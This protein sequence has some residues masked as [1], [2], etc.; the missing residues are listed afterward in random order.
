MSRNAKI[1]VGV[2]IVV[3][4][5][6]VWQSLVGLGMLGSSLYFV[7]SVAESPP[8]YFMTVD[9]LFDQQEKLVE[10]N[11]R[12]SGAVIGESIEFDETSRTLSFWIA[13]VPGDYDEVEEQGGLAMVLENAVRDPNRRRIQVVYVGEKPEL[14]RDMTQAIVTGQLHSDGIFYAEELLLKC[15]SRYEEAVPDQAVD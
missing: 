13:D 7:N 4:V 5:V 15:P 2:V 6:G 11:I 1:I 8:E 3:V 9:E 14:L 10:S 12:L